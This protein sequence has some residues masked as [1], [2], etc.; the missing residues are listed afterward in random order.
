M[1]W[2]TLSQTEVYSSTKSSP[3]GLSGEAAIG[4][5]HDTGPNEIKVKKSR[6]VWKL[7]LSQFSDFM[8]LI[9]LMAA[10]VSAVIGDLTDA[11]VILVILILNALLGF[12]QEFR[13]ERALEALKELAFPSATVIRDGKIQTIP[14]SNLVP[15]DKVMLS[16]G[17][18]I[19]ADLRL[20]ETNYLQVDESSLTGE[21][22]P[23]EKNSEQIF[24]VD[25]PLAERLNMA[26]KSSLV[27]KG[28]GSGIVVATGMETEIGK[29]AGLLHEPEPLTPLQQRLTAFSK[30]LAILIIAIC[31][32]LFFIGI[33]QGG[34]LLEMLLVAI[35]LAVAAIPEALPAVVTISLALGARRLIKKNALIRKLPAVE[36]LGSVT[37]ICSDKTG[38]ITQNQMKVIEVFS[39]QEEISLSKDYSLLECA[40][41]LNNDVKSDSN[42]KWI[43]DPT[44]VALME[45][46]V[47]KHGAEHL[48]ETTNMLPR[49]AEIPFDAERKI[50]TT[51][52][53]WGNKYLVISKGAVEKI[54]RRLQQQEVGDVVVNQNQRLAKRGMR[55]L[56]F[57]FR[58]VEELPQYLESIEQN[59]EF[60]GLVG[61][62]DPPRG[63]VRS[64]IAQCKTAGIRPV[65]ITGDHPITAQAIA[66]EIGIWTSES[67]LVTGS[68]LQM[69]SPEELDNK[70]ENIA[71]YA[72]VS[73]EQKLNIVKS[74]QRREQFVAMTGDGVND[75]PSL[76]TAN[77]GVAMGITGTDVSKQ[78]AHMILLDDNFATIVSTVRE[79]RHIFD[80]IRKFIKYTM[81]SNSGE[82]WTLFLAPLIG[83]PIPL[84]PIHILWINLVTDGLPGLALTFE[85]SE[86]DIMQ[87]P[88]RT[89]GEPIFAHGMG[90][91]ILWVGL[92]MGAVCLALQA[93]SFEMGISNWQTMIFTV[94]CL[95]QL[96]HVLAIKS[97]GQLLFRQG[98]LSNPILFGTV[99]LTFILQMVIIYLPFANDIFKTEPLSLTE[100]G[101]CLVASLIVFHAVELEKWINIMRQQRGKKNT[102][103]NL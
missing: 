92:L 59:L 51:I 46:A 21:S 1:N 37:Y 4:K 32:A 87:R 83:L 99:V 86:K 95:S 25:T 29:I 93:W 26:Y 102:E 63:E 20:T 35:S 28:N 82:I 74:L 42:N 60:A 49:L 77:I 101:I 47:N 17:D 73:P 69:L 2:H 10:A 80:N 67:Y 79:G 44:E 11:L 15:G 9:L 18:A 89:P 84:L 48:T 23:V 103:A 76:K 70:V 65:M 56:G 61:M 19:P 54:M 81:T 13:A 64:A 91:H 31:V 7:L 6:P 71:V 3:E 96:G 36:T 5:L 75:A 24:Q 94:L 39:N 66:E 41:A 55:V 58:V 100:L 38:T 62:M 50:M 40:M 16:S 98:L 85:P 52:H 8:I 45:F 78:A 43:G 72:R 33:W 30:R 34:D 22:I 97:E 68:E 90:R 53:S 27:T 12:I 14:A 88:P 57:G